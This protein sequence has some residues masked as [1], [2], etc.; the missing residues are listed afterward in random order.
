MAITEPYTGSVSIDTT[1]ISLVSGTSSL[2][3]VTD[4]GAYQVWLDLSALADGDIFILRQYEKVRS[5][6]TK[7][8]S[9]VWT[10]GHGQGADGANWKTL[11]DLLL[12]GWD[13]TLIKSA[14]TAR[15]IPWSIRKVA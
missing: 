10:I 8:V 9:D 2:Q 3:S 5:G 6:D 11:A 7:R 4:D 13:Y 14:G 12:H 1:E 15:T